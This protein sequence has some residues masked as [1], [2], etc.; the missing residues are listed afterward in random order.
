MPED[1]KKLK[2]IAVRD[3]G[4]D[5]SKDKSHSLKNDG[6][7]QLGRN[8]SDAHTING[9][10]KVSN[11]TAESLV[12]GDEVR[13]NLGANH[14]AMK[15]SDASTTTAMATESARFVKL[16]ESLGF[17]IAVVP[18][19]F[20]RN[21][22]GAT[23]YQFKANAKSMGMSKA[24]YE[25]SVATANAKLQLDLLREA[26]KAAEET[27]KEMQ[28]TGTKAQVTAAQKALDDAVAATKAQQTIQDAAYATEAEA[29][30]TSEEAI[31]GYSF[32]SSFKQH[33]S[34]LDDKL[35]SSDVELRDLIGEGAPNAEDT[36]FYTS[37]LGWIERQFD[38]LI[39]DAPGA[40][41][42]LKMI[43]DSIVVQSNVL[44]IADKIEEIKDA[45]AAGDIDLVNELTT[46][47]EALQA[48]TVK[49]LLNEAI[50]DMQIR[51]YGSPFTA[52]I[53][54]FS[55]ELAAQEAELKELI[56]AGASKEET[57]GVQ[58]LVD[59]T[60]KELQFALEGESDW[61]NDIITGQ[62]TVSADHANNLLEMINVAKETADTLKGHID[63]DESSELR[64]P[65][66]RGEVLM[67]YVGSTPTSVSGTRQFL[68]ATG[69][70][71]D[72]NG[73]YTTADQGEHTSHDEAIFLLEK[74]LDSRREE[75]NSRN[76]HLSLQ[77][78]LNSEVVITEG[79][80]SATCAGT[81]RIPRHTR[82]TFDAVAD[83]T[84]LGT[85]DAAYQQA[86]A[87][88]DAAENAQE[89]DPVAI[90]AAND[91]VDQTSS[92]LQR[93][94]KAYKTISFDGSMVFLTDTT[95]NAAHALPHGRKLYFREG[96]EWFASSFYSETAE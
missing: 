60:S 32:G 15:A 47:L 63:Y 27:L 51:V 44:A 74:A 23:E 88:R 81:L 56:D 48:K 49:E 10:L 85:A 37:G 94:V 42:T 61:R 13:T 75:L 90:R 22:Y 39:G 96:K 59:K 24:C 5:N 14:K 36:S 62:T 52:Q 26:E 4:T 17:N 40:L 21:P 3:A 31:E 46:E 78:A 25:A 83:G 82:A 41:S 80:T 89:P 1:T 2:G 66:N 95:T 70:V 8:K 84:Q 64:R 50:A 18:S 53:A 91:T 57:D 55:A 30:K 71:V 33:V 86:V 11:Q 9:D 29:Q 16:A 77:G 38:E 45:D 58:K 34:Y 35:Y 43:Q 28:E 92:A 12:Y 69:D 20:G 19:E 93:A 67:E 76:Q 73:N 65:A 79:T 72:Y 54:E 6:S 87:V 7:F 68:G